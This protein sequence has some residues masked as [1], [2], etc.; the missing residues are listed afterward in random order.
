MR[1]FHRRSSACARSR[2]HCVCRLAGDRLRPPSDP[3]RGSD[4][5]PGAPA[6]AAY[7]PGCRA[8][9]GRQLGLALALLGVAAAAHAPARAAEL[10]DC[11]QADT[12]VTVSVSSDLDPACTWTRWT[13][14][15]QHTTFTGN[16]SL[17]QPVN[18]CAGAQP[19]TGPFVMAVALTLADPPNP[20]PGP[21]PVVPQPDPL[22]PCVTPC[23]SVASLDQPAIVIHRLDTPPGDDRLVFRGRM[24][25]PHPFSPLLDPV[26]RGVGV[27]LADAAGTRLLD[28][29]IPGGPFDPGTKVGW[30]TA[31]GGRRWVYLNRSNTPI[32]GIASV[33]V[34]DLSTRQPGLV[35]FSVKGQRGNYAV[36]PANLP[37]SGWLVLDPPTADTG[38]C[39]EASFAPP[40]ARCTVAGHV[41]RCG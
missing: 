27:R 32:D 8:R 1:G 19:W 28:V 15:H 31:P 34:E 14:A 17:G 7:A 39:G 5:G 23:S 21:A 33:V 6:G 22:P 18:L 20:P 16:Q 9:V 25:L 4:G 10:V 11:S 24:L 41:L 26:A 36:A 12:R 37:L 40:R 30:R 13:H 38:Q 29:V 2:G 3:L 35:K